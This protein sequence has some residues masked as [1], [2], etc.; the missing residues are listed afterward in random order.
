[1]NSS[2]SVESATGAM[3]AIDSSAVLGDSTS[4]SPHSLLE[5]VDSNEIKGL[6]SPSHSL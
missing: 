4:Q 5:F 3:L 1:M 2:E 6:K